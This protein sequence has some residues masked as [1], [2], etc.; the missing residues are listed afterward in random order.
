MKNNKKMITEEIAYDTSGKLVNGMSYKAPFLDQSKC[1][2]GIIGITLDITELKKTQRNL[3]E[4]LERAS[5]AEKKQKEFLKNQEHDINTAIS[6]IQYA[7]MELEHAEDLE[8]AHEAA[9]KISICAGRLKNYNKSLLRDLAWLE[10][11]GR[12]VEQRISVRKIISNLYELNSL[13]ASNKGLEFTTKICDDMPEFFIGDEIILF[14]C[15]QNLVANSIRFTERGQIDISV[16]ILERN[17]KPDTMLLAFH[18]KDTGRGIDAKHQRYIFDDFYKVIPSNEPDPI[19]G[20]EADQDKGRGIG[21]TLSKKYV[22]A[23]KGQ[24]HLHW[25]E[26]GK[27]S[28]F[29]ITIPLCL[30]LNQEN[31]RK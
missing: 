29:V 4:A 19:T 7:A 9:R 3:E 31:P 22:E 5:I 11:K 20:E 18:V 30:A 21:L 1:V 28:E 10:D 27:G 6:G 25:S 16:K 2:D 12:I 15:L 26:V 8:I 14:Q 24:I 17:Y 13:S 23:I